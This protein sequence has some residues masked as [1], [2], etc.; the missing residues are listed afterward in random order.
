MVKHV[1]LEDIPSYFSDATGVNLVTAQL[2]CSMAVIMLIVL[3]VIY[4]ARGRNATTIWLIFTFISECI[5]LGLGWL[6]FWIMIMTI[7]VTAL[8][9]SMK[10]SSAL[11]GG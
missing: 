7:A 8:G 10:I 3:P 9:L 1:S 4:L 11:S 6:P 2:I 5:V